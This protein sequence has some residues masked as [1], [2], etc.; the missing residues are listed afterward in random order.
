MVYVVVCALD[1][2][3]AIPLELG[4]IHSEIKHEEGSYFLSI[5]NSTEISCSESIVAIAVGK[6]DNFTL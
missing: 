4:A 1:N 3:Q 6:C 2:F 5:E